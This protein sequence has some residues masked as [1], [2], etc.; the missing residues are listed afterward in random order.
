METGLYIHIPFCKS[1]CHYCDFCSVANADSELI[2]R[3]TNELCRRMHEWKSRC[4][5]RKFDTVY[6]GGGT[7][8][9]LNA[10]QSATVLDTAREC[11]DILPDAEITV[12]CNPATASEYSL[13]AWHALGVNRLSIGV[14]S[15]VDSEL[16]LLGRIHKFADAEETVRAARA[17]GIDNI[18]IDLMIG[19]PDQTV[20]S[21]EYTLS[22]YIELDCSHVSAYC[23]SVE[24]GTR[25][26][27]SRD[28]LNIADADAVADM[29]SLVAKRLS[30]SGY[31]HYEISNFAKDGCRSRHNTHTWQ[32]REYL[33]LGVAAYSYFDGERFGNSRD[34]EA[35]LRGENIVCESYRPDKD[36]RM[37]EYVMLGLRLRGGIDTREFYENFGV[38]FDAAYGQRCR[39]FVVSGHLKIENGRVFLTKQGWLVSNAVLSEIL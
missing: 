36:E 21:L 38:E 32:C 20:E 33:G 15:A 16:R 28:K 24:E 9:L 19:I 1:K 12:E 4:R 39:P 11:F 27:K 2:A 13:A 10:D 30:E 34:I 18:N 6:L 14:Q 35:F 3:Y 17:V 7:P 8:T 25:F 23:L 37:S 29:Y 26:Y 22:R 31:E 5:Q